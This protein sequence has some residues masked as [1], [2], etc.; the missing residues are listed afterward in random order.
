MLIEEAYDD[1]LLV[2]NIEYQLNQRQN[3]KIYKHYSRFSE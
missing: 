2:N 3:E 1:V